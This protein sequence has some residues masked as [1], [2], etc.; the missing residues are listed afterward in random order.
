MFKVLTSWATTHVTACGAARIRMKFTQFKLNICMNHDNLSN[1]CRTTSV[2]WLIT[3][4]TRRITC[5]PQGLI[6]VND[7]ED[8]GNGPWLVSLKYL[9]VTDLRFE[10][11]E[12]STILNVRCLNHNRSRRTV[13]SLVLQ[14]SASALF[15]SSSLH[16]PLLGKYYLV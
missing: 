13:P 16:S 3:I 4:R 6:S 8:F 2:F 12:T 7:G 9:E 15:P 5:S 10:F 11:L 14:T 1:S